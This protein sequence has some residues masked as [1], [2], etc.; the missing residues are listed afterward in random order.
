MT[1]SGIESSAFRLV[2]YIYYIPVTTT[3]FPADDLQNGMQLSTSR[4]ASTRLHYVTSQKTVLPVF[5]PL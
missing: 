1:L 5:I 2:A 3:L 4:L